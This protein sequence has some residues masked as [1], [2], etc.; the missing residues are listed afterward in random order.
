MKYVQ[1]NSLFW[2]VWFP[3]F[4]FIWLLF[5]AIII[6]KIKVVAK[7]LSYI[8]KASLSIMWLHMVIIYDIRLIFPVSNK[9]VLCVVVVAI[10]TTFYY[11]INKQKYMRRLFCGYSQ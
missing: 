9:Y 1:Y 11:F 6:C 5:G 3:V 2:N 7:I 8:G 4:C 10:G